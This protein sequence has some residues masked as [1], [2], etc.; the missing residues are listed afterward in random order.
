MINIDSDL[1]FLGVE[2]PIEEEDLTKKYYELLES[3][4]ESLKDAITDSYV[5]VLSQ[6]KVYNKYSR[7]KEDQNN[8][9]SAFFG[10]KV[11]PYRRR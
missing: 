1:N 3:N 11:G 10:G 2:W 5:R 4:D 9:M 8:F 6:L 7:L